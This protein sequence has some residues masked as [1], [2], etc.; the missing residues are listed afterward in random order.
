MNF[1]ASSKFKD[2][3]NYKYHCRI[4]C[5]FEAKFKVSITDIVEYKL[6]ACTKCRPQT[7]S[8]VTVDDIKKINQIL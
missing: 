5:G 1:Y 2:L 6:V 3:P 7:F 8:T 4:N